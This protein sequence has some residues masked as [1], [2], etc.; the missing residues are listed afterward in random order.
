MEQYVFVC[1]GSNK[2]ISDSFGPR[3]GE[4]LKSKFYENSNIKVFGTMEKP[5]H[6]LN[7]KCVLEQLKEIEEKIIL[8]D[9]AISKSEEIG[10]TY[11]GTGG[12][13]IGKAYGKSFY[14]PAYLNIKTVVANKAKVQALSINEID[15]LAQK[16]TE[17]IVNTIYNLKN[18]TSAY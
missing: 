11:I 12:I 1:I 14:F 7:A 4:K 8:I 16:L 3:V 15:L 9:S 5:I 2:I 13:E 6:F 17:Q 10:A 18:I